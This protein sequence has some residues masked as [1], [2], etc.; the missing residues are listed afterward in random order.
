MITKYRIFTARSK[1]KPMEKSELVNTLKVFSVPERK[2]LE[3]FLQSPYCTGAQDTAQE[4]SLIN[5]I[6]G[7]L[8]DGQSGNGRLDRHLL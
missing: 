1:Q 7:V 2:Q 3:L 5:Y 8:A 4:L 6:F